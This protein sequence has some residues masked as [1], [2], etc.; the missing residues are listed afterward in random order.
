MTKQTHRQKWTIFFTNISKI[1]GSLVS[2]SLSHS[3][4]AFALLGANHSLSAIVIVIMPR[5]KSYKFSIT[6]FSDS[7][8][9]KHRQQRILPSQHIHRPWDTEIV[10]NTRTKKSKSEMQKKNERRKQQ[11]KR[12][13]ELRRTW[14]R[15]NRW[16]ECKRKRPRTWAKQKRKGKSKKRE[17]KGESGENKLTI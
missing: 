7:F 10:E 6:Y 9:S 16:T 13:N 2:V 11:T 17:R 1:A 14:Q 3:P 4:F 12:S 8:P 15:T 5:S